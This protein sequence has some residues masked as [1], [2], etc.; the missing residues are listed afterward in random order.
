MVV[1]FI[2][3]SIFDAPMRGTD[4][5]G[6]QMCEEKSQECKECIVDLQVPVVAGNI[7]EIS[8]GK[9][10]SSVELRAHGRALY[11]LSVFL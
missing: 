7:E 11:L 5:R 2:P 3:V 6:C 1:V 10:S 9:L 8:V 4:P